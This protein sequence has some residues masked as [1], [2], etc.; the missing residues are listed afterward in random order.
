MISI[1]SLA[2]DDVQIRNVQLYVDGEI[3][4]TDGNY[5]FDFSSVTPLISPEVSS[6][7]IYAVATD[8]GGNMTTSEELEI[9]LVPDI[10]PPRVKAVIPKNAAFTGKVSVVIGVMNEPINV[11]TLTPETFF[12]TDA[13]PDKLFGTDDDRPVIGEL[14]F[15]ETTNRIS[16]VSPIDLPI[17]L[18]QLSVLAP[19]SDL[20]GNELLESFFS[21]FQVLG[22]LDSDGDGL[23]DFW[24]LENGLDPQNPDTNNNG[25][26]DGEEDSDNDNLPNIGE[27]L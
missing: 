23:P 17:G 24:E 12:V 19:L 8:T 18:Y 11:D 2:A 25:T 26:P 16:W 3:A 5:P 14:S 15:D 27:F 6:F 21:T 4:S 22:Y 7:S 1:Q 13:G 10:T 20:A 9:T